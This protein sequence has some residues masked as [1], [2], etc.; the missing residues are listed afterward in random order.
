MTTTTSAYLTVVQNLPRMQA[1]T[2]DQPTVKTAS[3]YYAANIGKVTSIDQF[4]GNYRL[5]SYALD[6]YGLGDQI[7]STALIKQVLE[8]GV[9]N[10][11][12]LANTLPQWKAF[13][14][15]F[16][17]ASAG[18]SSISTSTAIKDTQSEYVEQTLENN[19]GQQDVGVQLAMYFNRVAP[20]V[21]S[22]YGILADQNLLEVVETIFGLPTAFSSENID[23]QAQAVSKLLPISDLQNPAKLKELTE[24]FT[25]AYDM[26]Y[27]NS[28][29][30]SSTL[31]VS[32]SASSS[33]A[34]PSA[35]VTILSGIIN[36]NSTSSS[37]SS[38]LFSN[39]LLQSLQGFSLGG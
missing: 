2:A 31:S 3:A 19:E 28:S 5:L 15:A 24:R 18:A 6:A 1:M 27:G 13:A 39:A 26:T 34:S 35:A 36:G 8:G 23:V 29:N 7:N 11:K 20:S 37:G 25:A 10:P 4:V 16:N 9:T 12:S 33:S 21:T 22:S 32:G 30:S 14:T 17:F 38:S